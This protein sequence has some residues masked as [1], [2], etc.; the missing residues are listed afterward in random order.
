MMEGLFMRKIWYS[1]LGS[2]ACTLLILSCSTQKNDASGVGATKGVALGDLS[3]DRCFFYIEGENYK[4][5]SGGDLDY[6]DAAYGKKCLGMRW[7]EK[8][9]DFADY[10]VLLDSPIESAI[11]VVRVAIDNPKP[12]QYEIVLDDK[13]IQSAIFGPTGGYG[14]T[15]K[16]WRC[17]T[18]P[19]GR[20]EKGSHILKL[21]PSKNG[22]I[23]N[24]DSLALGKS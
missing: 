3:V 24:I 19:L 15:E 2:L 12:L 4:D 17:Y 13:T 9:T 16:E 18:V 14:Y 5:K 21:R 1:I 20:V 23:A 6:K 10:A 22:G 7:G 8:T 11:L